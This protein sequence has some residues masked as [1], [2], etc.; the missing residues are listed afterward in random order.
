[1][2]VNPQIL[3]YR[4][5]ISSL[6]IVLVVLGGYS[7]SSY[8]SLKSHE[9]FL[10]QEKSLIEEELSVMLFNFNSISEDYNFV[11]SDFEHAK[12]KIKSA[13]DSLRLLIYS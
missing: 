1:M 10:A 5:I 9:S 8:Q 6:V 7:Y 2:I 13:L 4:L 11:S 12:I 3:N